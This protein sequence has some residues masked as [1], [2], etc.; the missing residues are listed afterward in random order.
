ML[1]TGACLVAAGM[2]VTGGAASSEALA[3]EISEAEAS[4]WMAPAAFRKSFDVAL[5]CSMG[6]TEVLSCLAILASSA[7]CDLDFA[8]RG[9]AWARST[10]IGSGVSSAER[11]LERR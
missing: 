9:V 11:F 2:V 6:R 4:D 5:R 7:I 10:V 3:T 1:T 8:E